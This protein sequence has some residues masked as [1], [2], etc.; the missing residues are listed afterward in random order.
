MQVKALSPSEFV[1]KISS[2]V[3]I[4]TRN[5]VSFLSR[6][7]KDSLNLQNYNLILNILD[8]NKIFKPVCFVCFSSRNAKKA[9][10]QFVSL[11][12]SYQ[13]AYTYYLE[14]S[15][16]ELDGLVE[17]VEFHSTNDFSSTISPIPPPYLCH[18]SNQTTESNR[19]H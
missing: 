18:L 8:K 1:F 15:I 7:I 13:H 12:P 6:H 5:R 3:V 17:F 16:M 4:D 9:A 11:N 14:S 2:L 19:P 10:Y